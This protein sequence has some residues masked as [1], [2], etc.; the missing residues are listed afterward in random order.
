MTT[1]YFHVSNFNRKLPVFN[2]NDNVCYQGNLNEISFEII[3]LL[4]SLWQ[5]KINTIQGMLKQYICYTKMYIS[6]N[7]EVFNV[8][9]VFSYN[10]CFHMMLIPSL[11]QY[12]CLFS[13]VKILIFFHKIVK[14]RLLPEINCYR[15]LKKKCLILISKWPFSFRGRQVV[16]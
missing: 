4:V 11:I 3:I 10:K 8:T 16:I 5:H 15:K 6:L 2:N 13:G 12:I 14:I 7:R 1:I 9:Q